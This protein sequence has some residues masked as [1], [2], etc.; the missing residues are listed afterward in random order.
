MVLGNENDMHTPHWHG[1]TL[2]WNGLRVD[3]LQLM[4]AD[5]Q[6]ADMYAANPGKIGEGGKSQLEAES[7]EL[8]PT[9]H[10]DVPLPR[11]PPHP[12]RHDGHV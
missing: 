12:W 7:F 11:Q 8:R 4:P 3:V 6:V 9:R 2:L 5:V 10:V 1:N